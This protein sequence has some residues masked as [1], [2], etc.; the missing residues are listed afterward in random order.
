MRGATLF[1][2]NQSKYYEPTISLLCANCHG[3]HGEGGS[4]PY[5]LAPELDICQLKKN[6]NNPNV[7]QCLPQQVEWTAPPLNTVLYRFTPS[8]LANII[9]YGRPGTP[10]P[11]W[12]VASGKGVLGT[13]GI[14]DLVNYLQSIQITLEEGPG[15]M[16][17]GH[18]AV[19]ERRPRR[20]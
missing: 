15:R 10:M 11:P 7:P 3:V 18:R 13:Q 19:Q 1:A 5:T 9:T 8:E 20:T 12:G 16:R 2:N 17:P 6:Q 4:T 14:E